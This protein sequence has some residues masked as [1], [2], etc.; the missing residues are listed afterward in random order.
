MQ[1]ESRKSGIPSDLDQDRF[2]DCAC[3]P[4]Q[5]RRTSTQMPVSPSQRQP[6][7]AKRMETLSKT[8]LLLPSFLDTGQLVVQVL[9]RLMDHRGW[10]DPILLTREDIST[11]HCL[12]LLFPL[13]RHGGQRPASR[14]Q[15][16]RVEREGVR[17]TYITTEATT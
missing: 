11:I 8:R 9:R 6:H 4:L 1:E 13:E 15:F 12:A 2:V 5:R 10:K 17:W 7:R 14:S 3:L 16:A